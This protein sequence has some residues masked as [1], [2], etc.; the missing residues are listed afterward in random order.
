MCIRRKVFPFTWK[1]SD[2]EEAALG[3]SCGPVGYPLIEIFVRTK[4]S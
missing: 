3:N 2:G 1:S 4:L